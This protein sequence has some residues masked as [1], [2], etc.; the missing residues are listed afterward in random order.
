MDAAHRDE[1]RET[2]ALAQ[3]QPPGGQ[4]VPR[5]A[6]AQRLQQLARP[7]PAIRWDAERRRSTR[8]Q[9]GRGEERGDEGSGR[10]VAEREGE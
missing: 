6:A 8:R 3:Q 10:W 2:A 9:V 1:G 7:R 5:G 4:G